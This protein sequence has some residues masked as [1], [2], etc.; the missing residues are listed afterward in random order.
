MTTE[1]TKICSMD[2]Y[3]FEEKF[4]ETYPSYC[5]DFS[6]NMPCLGCAFF[7]MYGKR[8]IET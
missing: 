1:T 6:K 2:G 4:D 7:E 3:I 5:N 8:R